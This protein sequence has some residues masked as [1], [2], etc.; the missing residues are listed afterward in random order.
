MTVPSALDL[1]RDGIELQRSGD[2]LGASL[3]YQAALKSDR[4]CLI[5]LQNLGQMA[6]DRNELDA[7]RAY[8]TRILS[9][10]PGDGAQWNNLGNILTR[11]EK[12]DSAREALGRAA[13]LAPDM[14]VIWHNLGLFYL[15]TGEY[16][17]ALACFERTERMGNQTSGLKNDKAHA[18][19]YAGD[20]SAA[21]PLY[22]SRWATLTHLP[23]WD[24]H[25][26]EWQGQDLAGKKILVHA[27]Q[28]FGDSIMWLRFAKRLTSAG[29]DLTLG[30]PR[31]LC[32]LFAS[33]GFSVLAIESMTAENMAEFDLQSPMFSA[34]RWL[35]ID[36]SDISSRPYISVP[37]EP[38]A[39]SGTD[40]F[41][42]AARSSSG[43]VAFR[44][45]ICWAS[46]RRNSDHDWRGRYTN[47]RD[48]LALAEIPGVELVSLQQGQDA[49]E[50]GACGAEGLIDYASIAG[51]RDWLM[52]AN[53][54]AGLDLVICVDTAVAHLAGA[55][56]KQ[57]WMLSQ[58]AHCWRWWDIKN[59]TGLPW[60][61]SMKIIPQ[62]APGGWKDQLKEVH[63]W[64]LAV[65]IPEAAHEASKE[66]SRAIAA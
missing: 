51:A 27:E 50:I 32:S 10:I 11:A 6:N 34:L 22:E 37:E 30:L 61:L 63:R 1:C 5:A 44:V 66:D 2:F 8:T 25:I 64:L 40:S 48:W 56:G 45:G 38:P 65:A 23:P 28:G 57:V 17:N 46:G 53:I 20:L 62:A 47:L 54:I 13:D 58:F 15:R 41:S 42:S 55:M 24:Y 21:W 33:Q 35:K 59:G 49:D 3:H 60:Y 16:E 29:A 36:K 26:P 39:T 7:A 9:I 19:L 52:T 18:L 43:P 12:Y 4:N 14:P 31:C